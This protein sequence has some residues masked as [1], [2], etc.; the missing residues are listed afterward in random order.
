MNDQLAKWEERYGRGDGVHDFKPSPPLPLAASFAE[1]GLALDLA[2]GAGRHALFLAEHSWRVIAVEGTRAGIDLMLAEAQRRGV[3]GSIDARHADLESRP[4]GFEI[5]P[6]TYDL[7]CDLYFLDRSL[8]DEIR[9]GVRPRGL[10]AAAIHIDDPVASEASN[11]SFV[12]RPGELRSLVDGW[13]WQ[14]LHSF[15]G[16]PREGGHQRATAEVVARRPG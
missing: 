3:E 12:L 8:F 15:E 1:P 6:N 7:I 16:A 4:R 5:E 14:I 10:F 11:R 9:A 13:G 2:A